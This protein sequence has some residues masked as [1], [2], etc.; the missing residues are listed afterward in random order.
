MG[1]A[2]ST[3]LFGLFATAA[4]TLLWHQFGPR[5]PKTA[6]GPRG[7]PLIGNLLDVPSDTKGGAFLYYREL[8]KKFGSCNDF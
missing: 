5:N 8:A 7:L 2:I 4:V 3:A 1:A 6:P